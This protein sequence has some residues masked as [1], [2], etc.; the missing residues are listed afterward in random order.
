MKP[1]HESLVRWQRRRR[2][3][4]QEGRILKESTSNESN[5]M[6]LGRIRPE[7]EGTRIWVLRIPLY[8]RP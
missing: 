8:M 5:R 6:M 3:V 7:S 2:R 4:K 1:L